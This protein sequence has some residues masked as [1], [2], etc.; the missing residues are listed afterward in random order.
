[1]S[2]GT[3]ASVAIV[4]AGLSGLATAHFLAGRGLDTCLIESDNR[5]GGTIR[6]TRTNGFLIEHGPNSVL[7][8]TPLLHQLAADLGMKSGAD[9]KA[10]LQE[11][12]MALCS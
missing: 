12:V 1:M 3:D 8:T 7:D 5:P 9:P 4:G 10:T 6:T 2:N 11:L